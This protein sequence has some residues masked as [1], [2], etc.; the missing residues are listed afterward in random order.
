MPGTDP[1]TSNQQAYL[2]T[3]A[4]TRQVYG[5]HANLALTLA[6]LEEALPTMTKAEASTLIDTARNAPRHPEVEQW[7]SERDLDFLRDQ[8]RTRAVYGL[9][10]D[11]DQTLAKTEEAINTPGFTLD[12]ARALIQQGYRAVPHPTAQDALLLSNVEGIGDL[13][14]AEGH[15]AVYDASDVLRF[16]RIYTATSGAYRGN[17]VMRRYAS[18]NLLGLYPEEARFVLHAINADPDAAAYRYS[19]TFTNCWVCGRSLT[20]AVSRLMSVGPTCRGF[21][22]HSGLRAAATEVDHNTERR[23]VFRALRRWALERGFRDPATREDRTTITMTASRVASAWSGIPGI[24]A[25]EPD[26][27]VEAVNKALS[28]GLDEETRNN[29]LAAPADTLLILIESGVLSPDVM[30]ALSSHKSQAV[31]TATGEHLLRL[32]G[33]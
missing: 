27:A 25:M 8:A 5:P 2:R 30:N 3:L 17:A 32:L 9:D 18:D 33:M 19:D 24:L 16:Y 12:K 23:A 11:I 29:L 20:D 28:E 10:Y 14:I 26:R 7:P 21:H 1:V 6:R 31:K 22:N 4:Q 13:S 15:Y